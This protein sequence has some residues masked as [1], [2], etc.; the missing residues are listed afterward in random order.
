MTP[1]QGG[2]PRRPRRRFPLA[3]LL[4]LLALPRFAGAQVRPD[5]TA[6]DS[7]PRDTLRVPIPPD[8]VSP[9]T[10]PNDSTRD[11]ARASVPV[12]IFPRYPSPLPTGW[13]AARW[14]WDREA[15]WRYQGFTLLE[16]LERTPGLTIVR[17]GDHGQPVGVTAL[18]LGG[19]RLRVFLDGF[20]IDPL[21]YTAVDL[22]QMGTI[23]L[24]SVRVERDLTGVRIELNTIRLP[25]NR[26]FSA[27][28]A[29]TGVFQSKLLR[30]ALVRGIG[31]RSIVT[32]AYD[33]VTTEGYRFDFPFAM[34]NARAAWSYALSERTA[35]QAEIRNGG[36]ER[37]GGPYDENY[38][39][40]TI[41]IRGR[42]ELREGLVVDGALGRA[43]RK[44]ADEDPIKPELTSVQ[45]MLRASY[46]LRTGWAEASVRVRDEEL[47]ASAAPRLEI[48]ARGAFRPL[49][50]LST[51]GEVRTASV[52]GAGGLVWQATGRAGPIGAPSLFLSV[53]GGSQ[54]LGLVEDV[55]SVPQFSAVSSRVASV[56][57]G[58]EMNRSAFSMGLA[59]VSLAPA[60]I[61][62]FGAAFDRGLPAVEAG[63]A[64][65]VEAHF[66]A[67]IPRTRE[68]VRLEGWANYWPDR[69]D[70]PYLPE[71][72]S[73]AAIT[74]HGVFYDGQLEPTFSFQVSSRGAMRVPVLATGAF[75]ETTPYTLTNL[76]IQIRILD[77]QAFGLWENLFNYQTAAD[78]PDARLPGQR[79]VYGIRWVFRD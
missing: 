11:T 26:P 58:A 72:D 79:L 65:G 75:V 37:V 31:G 67:A 45:G 68:L 1:R 2:A 16:F 29:A 54:G 25:E 19:G 61:V 22:Q 23:D 77:V 38:D 71:L 47:V 69:G 39:R 20:E 10:L 36:V 17:S 7:V 48:G 15:L 52:G 35:F 33:A 57:A 51:E 8:A 46:A 21:G 66:A 64:S 24:E 4:L 78:L 70:R 42:S 53:A 28:E 5:S 12:A 13:S 73:R 62:P 56:R 43:W 18:G 34:V 76:F 55:D 59:G 41:L 60:D 30:G 40:R 32:A 44:P 9:D 27:V 3:L 6:P 49:P 50:W 63:S 14:E 74:A